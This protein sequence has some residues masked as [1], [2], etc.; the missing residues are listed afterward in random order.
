MAA[1]KVERL[2]TKNELAAR[3]KRSVS[4]INGWL[5]KKKIPCRVLSGSV[6][7]IRSMRVRFTEAQVLAIE[8]KLKAGKIA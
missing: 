7:D 1:K 2:F 5:Q 6:E 3:I 4:D 8:A